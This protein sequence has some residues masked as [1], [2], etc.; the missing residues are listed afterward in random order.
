RPPASHRQA[1]SP[2]TRGLAASAERSQTMPSLRGA[3]QPCSAPFEGGA[4]MLG[5]SAKLGSHPTLTLGGLLSMLSPDPAA[6]RSSQQDRRLGRRPENWAGKCEG[7]GPPGPL[8]WWQAGF[9][10]GAP[11]PRLPPPPARLRGQPL[12]RPHRRNTLARFR[13]G[14]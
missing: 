11:F 12:N 1:S 6:G 9:L 10:P 5:A 2:A 14:G 13:A 7:S 8:S 4:P 3:N